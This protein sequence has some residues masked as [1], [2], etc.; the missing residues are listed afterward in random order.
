MK[1]S[2][3][4]TIGDLRHYRDARGPVKL[5]SYM[6]QSCV[7]ADSSLFLTF[8]NGEDFIRLLIDKATG[9][10]KLIQ[11]M[12]YDLDENKLA[13][14]FPIHH[15]GARVGFVRKPDSDDNPMLALFH[16][17]PRESKEWKF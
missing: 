16:Y 9:K 15:K 6:L 13:G 10:Y 8:Y 17:K 4:L 5:D 14:L 1:I 7:E 3:T 2:P 11:S 12:P